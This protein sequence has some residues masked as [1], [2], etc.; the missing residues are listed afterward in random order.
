M[1]SLFD[2]PAVDLASIMNEQKKGKNGVGSI[3]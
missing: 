1:P 3:P 2:E